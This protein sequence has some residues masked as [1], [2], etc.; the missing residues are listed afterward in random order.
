MNVHISYKSGKT[1]DVEREFQLQI[2]KLER[3]LRVFRP[4][5]VHLHAIVDQQDGQGP[6]ASLNL[7]L[8]SGQMAVQNTAENVLAAV[9]TAFPDLIAQL[10]KHKDLLRGDF[11]RK[12]RLAGRGQVIEPIVP[13]EETFASVS[14]QE[15]SAPSR[16]EAANTGN[17]LETWFNA[18]MGKLKEFIDRE[19]QFRV[20]SDQLR[21]DQIT[22]EEVIDEVMVS[23]LSQENGYSQ[24][25][26][27]E[28][29]FQRF[30]LQA[31]RRLTDDNS[32]MAS[33][34]LEAPARAQNV[35][36]SDENVLQYHQ[37]DD[38]P[39]EEAVIRDEN[40]RTPEEIYAG[41]EMVSQ[42]D[43]VLHELRAKDREAFVLYT[44]EGFT[45]DEIARLSDRPPD[46][47]RQS[48]HHARE[49]VQQK[50]PERNEFRRSLLSRSRVA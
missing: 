22:G 25:L 14:R 12:R 7:R 33:V 39:Q 28:A 37:P 38:R 46:Q 45:I 36:G 13:F 50:L 34:S 49:R 17:D 16:T 31:I 44:L 15:T 1:P 3:R 2:Q 11:S 32:E 8:P 43:L 30:A 19:L 24:F 41:E 29:S 9:K 40:V 35:T 6:T 18:N 47:V 23:A 26:S 10:T 20:N 48:I 27:E 5:L 4:D 21:P 42:L